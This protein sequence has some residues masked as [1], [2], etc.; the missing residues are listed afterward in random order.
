MPEPRVLMSTIRQALQLPAES[1]LS[2]QQLGA[3]LGIS[4]TTVSEIATYARLRATAR[5]A[6]A[7]VV[8]FDGGDVG[9]GGYSPPAIWSSGPTLN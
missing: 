3:T 4:K 6:S 8:L 7:V 2:T 5:G 9:G 1:G